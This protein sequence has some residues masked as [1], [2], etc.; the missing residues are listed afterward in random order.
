MARAISR[1]QD[2]TYMPPPMFAPRE[3]ARAVSGQFAW[4]CG[5]PDEYGRCASPQHGAGCHVVVE[6]AAANGSADAVRAWRE[7]LSRH[8]GPV[9]E[10][11]GQ[12]DGYPDVSGLAAALHLTGS[13][14]NADRRTEI[15]ADAMARQALG[16]WR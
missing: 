3:P 15:A 6:S 4:L 10:P 9:P 2:G 5:N 12:G 8:P 7:V 11:G 13:S 1:V 14:P 16:G